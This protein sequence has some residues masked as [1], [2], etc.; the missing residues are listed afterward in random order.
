MLDDGHFF[1]NEYTRMT[2]EDGILFIE[3]QPNLIIT[4]EI[5]QKCVGDRLRFCKGKSYPMLADITTI[6]ASDK[7][8]REYLSSEEGIKGITAGAFMVKSQ[9]TRLLGTV[10]LSLNLNFNAKRPPAKLFV[11]KEDAKEWLKQYRMVG[12]I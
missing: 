6:K 9:F 11:D 2:I 4:L 5:A 10:F 3:Y 12:Q 1:E 8:A 7:E